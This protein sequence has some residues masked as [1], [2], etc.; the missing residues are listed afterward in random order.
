M[1]LSILVRP[2]ETPPCTMLLKNSERAGLITDEYLDLTPWNWTRYAHIYPYLCSWLPSG[3]KHSSF[4]SQA[5]SH[6]GIYRI[7]ALQTMFK[8]LMNLGHS[9]YVNSSPNLGHK[10]C[11]KPERIWAI[12]NMHYVLQD[13][14][15]STHVWNLTG[16]GSFKSCMRFCRI[17]PTQNIN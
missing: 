7:W 16:F 6:T 2:Y 17:W 12:Q 5:W 11:M 15:Q 10:T 8:V 3:A 14:G 4:A 9:N 13:L 1:V